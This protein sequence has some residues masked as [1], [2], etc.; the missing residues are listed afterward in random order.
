MYNS[1][2][3]N[4]SQFCSHRKHAKKG[5]NHLFSL[6]KQKSFHLFFFKNN[7][8]CFIF[9]CCITVCICVIQKWFSSMHRVER[10]T[11][12]TFLTRSMY[13]SYLPGIKKF[14]LPPSDSCPVNR[15]ITNEECLLLESFQ[16]DVHLCF[17]VWNDVTLTK[18]FR[19]EFLL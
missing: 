8:N 1:H 15:N 9:G 7:K 14:G 17:E 13:L 6:T 16:R 11:V 5:T 19:D 12:H 4:M 3:F 2:V 18:Y 10:P